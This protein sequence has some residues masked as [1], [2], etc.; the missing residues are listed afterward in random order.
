MGFFWLVLSLHPSSEAHSIN[1]NPW[2][3]CLL[4]A[5]ESLEDGVL[6]IFPILHAL[7]IPIL[8]QNLRFLHGSHLLLSYWAWP[9]LL[10]MAIQH[11]EGSKARGV[12]EGLLEEWD[13]FG[14]PEV[15]QKQQWP[16]V[17]AWQVWE[18]EQGTT[19]TSR[20][21]GE[22]MLRR[23]AVTSAPAANLC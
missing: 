14:I 22:E 4:H 21:L 5:A 2:Q 15:M 11:L 6:L 1:T 12:L 7:L 10:K 23:M 9:V 8:N 17:G 16:C 20:A 13:T 3:S 19:G 18:G